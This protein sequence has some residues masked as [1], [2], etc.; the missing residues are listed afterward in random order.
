MIDP[1]ADRPIY[2]QV[3]DELR[4]HILTGDW[5]EGTELR[6]E[7]DLA[8]EYEVGRDAIRDALALLV[9]EGL[10][11]KR[12]GHRT[13][14]RHTPEVSVIPIPADHEV[15]ARP[16]TEAECRELGIPEGGWVLYAQDATGA[17]VFLE[18]ADR[19]R[20]RWQSRDPRAD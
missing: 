1:Q 18:P 7:D 12:R 2:R 15:G 6:A 14:V 13:R 9:A 11:E 4:G 3:A 5:P 17:Q 16:A 20:F 19:T 10:V 8:D